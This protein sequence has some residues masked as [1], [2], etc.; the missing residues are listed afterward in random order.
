MVGYVGS[1]G[2]CM[3]RIRIR[4]RGGAMFAIK[5]SHLFR[6]VAKKRFGFNM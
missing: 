1:V 6:G 5:A 3:G 4:N 2:K